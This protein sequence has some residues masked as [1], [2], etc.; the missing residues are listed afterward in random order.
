[1]I[2]TNSVDG[3]QRATMK[4]NARL[5]REEYRDYNARAKR[6]GYKNLREFMTIY[7]N[8]WCDNLADQVCAFEEMR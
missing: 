7:L 8:C 6:L 1:M 2:Y 3:V 5:T 4:I